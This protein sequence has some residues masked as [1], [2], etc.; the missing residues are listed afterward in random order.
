[1]IGLKMIALDD[2]TL[3]DWYVEHKDK[4]FFGDLKKF[5]S[6]NPVVAILWEGIEASVAIRN[7]LGS[8]K[9]REAAPGTIRGDFSMSKQYNIVHASDS[10]EAGDREQKLIF[11]DDEI[12]PWKKM[13]LD[14]I[15]APD[16][17]E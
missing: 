15:Y 7:I 8:T 12:F 5:M 13:N 14:Q 6:S 9:G 4:P 17:M 11:K 16:E 2:E 1:M 3:S 10:A